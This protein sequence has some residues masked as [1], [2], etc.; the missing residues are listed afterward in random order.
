MNK[1]LLQ[2]LTEEQI[3]KV[4]ACKNQEEV[5]AL[6]KEEGIELSDEQLEAVNGGCGTTTPGRAKSCPNCNSKDIVV[7]KFKK[8]NGDI[9]WFNRCKSCGYDWNVNFDPVHLD[10]WGNLIGDK[11]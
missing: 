2:G 1:D 6:A 10:P 9:Y 8:A 4:K 5:L 7:N 3:A 11:L